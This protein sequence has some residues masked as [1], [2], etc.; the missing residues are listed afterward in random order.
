[1]ERI[2]SKID[3]AFINLQWVNLFLEGRAK[4]LPRVGSDHSPIFCSCA[5]VPKQ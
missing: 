5:N 1:M 3:R 4:I 2:V